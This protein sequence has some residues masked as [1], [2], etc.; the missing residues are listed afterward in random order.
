MNCFIAVFFFFHFFISLYLHI[1]ISSVR[2]FGVLI[3]YILSGMVTGRTGSSLPCSHT[4]GC[5]APWGLRL[6]SLSRSVV[7]G[8]SQSV[9]LPSLYGRGACMRCLAYKSSFEGAN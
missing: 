7:L 2:S 5:V 6:R 9:W 8:I 1:F 3:G 4:Q